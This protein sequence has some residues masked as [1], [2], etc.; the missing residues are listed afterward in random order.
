MSRATR[1]AFDLRDSHKVLTDAGAVVTNFIDMEDEHVSGGLYGMYFAQALAEYGI[2]DWSGV[3][4]EAGNPLPA[5]VENRRLLM[6]DCPEIADSFLRQYQAP[7]KRIESEGN[8]SGP[9]LNG[10]SV[11]DQITA[12]PAGKPGT[13]AA[14]KAPKAKKASAPTSATTPKPPKDKPSS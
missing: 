8:A 11:G 1:Q 13:T 6:S 14:G 12:K 3:C 4:D 9:L 5:T 7:I 2:R 10:T